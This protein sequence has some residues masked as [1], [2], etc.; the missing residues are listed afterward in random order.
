MGVTLVS[1]IWVGDETDA[2]VESD[3]VGRPAASDDGGEV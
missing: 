1:T 3:V 2:L